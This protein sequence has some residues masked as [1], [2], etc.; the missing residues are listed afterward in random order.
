M[1]Y[2]AKIE[3]VKIFKRTTKGRAYAISYPATIRE[4]SGNVLKETDDLVMELVPEGLL[5]RKAIE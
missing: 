2:M 3:K 4:D 5:I 1:L